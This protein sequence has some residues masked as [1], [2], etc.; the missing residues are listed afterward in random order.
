MTCM[1]LPHVSKNSALKLLVA[2]ILVAALGNISSAQDQ[3]ANRA[4][5]SGQAWVGAE[6]ELAVEQRK[7][8][9]PARS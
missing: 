6:I 3:N 7:I 8:I 9:R 1:Q 2:L 5:G 4:A